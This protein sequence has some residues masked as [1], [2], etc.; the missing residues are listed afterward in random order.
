VYV[1]NTFKPA[2]ASAVSETPDGEKTEVDPASWTLHVQGRLLESG[3]PGT[4]DALE[5]DRLTNEGTSTESPKFGGFLTRLSVKIR[6]EKRDDVSEH[7]WDASLADP[8]A[9]LPDG[10]EVKRVGDADARVTITMHMNHEP[11]RVTLTP[12]F[13][14]LLGINA[15]V[16]KPKLIRHLWRYVEAHDLHAADDPAAATLDEKLASALAEP[17][18]FEETTSK[19]ASSDAGQGT[20]NFTRGEVVKFDA[21]V[22]FVCVSHTKPEPP[23]SFEYV[24]RTR[25]RKNPTA[26][27]CYDVFVDVPVGGVEHIA[28]A[29]SVDVNTGRRL[30]GRQPYTKNH[31]F[32]DRTIEADAAE[33]AR[34]D[35]RARAGVAKIAA[36]AKRRAF[37]LG[38]ANAPGAFVDHVVAAQARDM[39]V[40]RG[41]GSTQRRAERRTEMYKKPWL[42]EAATRY[43][44]S[45]KSGKSAKTKK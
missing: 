36:H 28:G 11:P 25:G 37:L 3:E 34:C 33:A 7:V 45:L 26:P 21:L 5:R 12:A 19:P 14:N 20:K 40:A 15:A 31:P 23:I 30:N 16:T 27:E 35:A 6:G 13:E 1:Y 8:R 4:A 43:V 29:G 24:V 42:D 39:P 9:P 10:F 2:T 44:A 22:Q 41:D 38:F 32:V 17:F 18:S